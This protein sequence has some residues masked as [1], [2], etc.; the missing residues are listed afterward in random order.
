MKPVPFDYK[1]PDNLDEVLEILSAKE[2][3]RIIAG[4]QSL[5]PMLAMRLARPSCLID[6]ARISSL[7]GIRVAND[8]LTIGATTRHVEVETSAAVAR[9]CPLLSAAMP[10]VGHAPIR[11]RGTIGGSVA[12]A[13]PAAEIPLVL[14][15]LGGELTLAS[16][17]GKRTIA[18]HDFLAGPMMTTAAEDECLTEIRVPT[19]QQQK[20]GVGFHEV[21]NRRSDFAIVSATA[22]IAIDEDGKCIACAVGLGGVVETPISL[23]SAFAT[24]V[25]TRPDD[26]KIQ[27]LASEAV[28][29]LSAMSDPSASASYRKRAAV[30][31]LCQAVGDAVQNASGQGQNAGG[32]G[33]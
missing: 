2:D 9:A 6:I 10:W 24:L 22:Q 21:A 33:R 32:Q 30:K 23:S 12:H 28:T 20:I 7:S 27:D 16:N 18:A 11:S 5:I 29:D 15:T 1:R 3:A 4:G 26:R 19:W 13:D 14:V 8:Y 25:G 31:L 17:A